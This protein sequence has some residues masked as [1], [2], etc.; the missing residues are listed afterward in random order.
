M[1][2]IDGGQT[3]L[4]EVLH[5]VRTSEAWAGPPHRTRRDV[6]SRAVAAFGVPR[7]GGQSTRTRA[8]RSPLVVRLAMPGLRPGQLPRNPVLLAKKQGSPAPKPAQPPAVHEDTGQ[9]GVHQQNR[10]VIS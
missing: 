7:T 10:K 6:G 4:S 5:A 2:I 9:R 8:A 3:A 1:V